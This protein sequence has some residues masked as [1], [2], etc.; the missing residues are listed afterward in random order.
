MGAGRALR[1]DALLH[2]ADGDPRVHEVGRRARRAGTTCPRCG[3]SARSASRSTRRP[4]SG[5]TRSIGGERCPIVDT[6]WQTETGAIMIT[7]LPGI[8]GR[9]SRAR[10]ARRCRAST[11]RCV[12]RG[13]R[14]RRHRAGPARRCAGRGRRCCARSTRRRTASSRPT[15]R[16]FGN[17]RLLRRRRRARATRTATSGSS[18]ASTTCINV[19]GHRHVDRRGRVGDRLAPE[20]RRGGGD[21]PARRG[22][23][24]GGRGVRDARGRPARATTSWSTRSASTSPSG[25]A[26]SRGRSAS[27]GPTTCPRRARARSCAACCATSPR[28]ASS[29]T[30]RRCATPT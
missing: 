2:R 9:P 30:S 13:G 4:G 27:S 14:G 18:G 12:D 11:P 19:S 20:G 15:G 10:P 17:G 1:R 7:T 24:P 21:R 3:C 29:A 26:S 25:S 16:K 5:T 8:A 6:W 23:R 28:A 22:H